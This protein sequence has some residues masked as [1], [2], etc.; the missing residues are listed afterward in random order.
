GIAAKPKKVEFQTMPASPSA[1]ILTAAHPLLGAVQLVLAQTA[2]AALDSSAK[3]SLGTA[4]VSLLLLCWVRYAVHTGLA[5]V[6]ILP[7]R[8]TKVLHST[9]PKYQLLRG[10]FLFLSTFSLF[11][12][13]RYL[14]QA[15]T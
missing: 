8:G 1:R 2:L 9:V 7:M 13:L 6:V 3:W 11:N 10:L 5:L 4:G 12:T 15:E 14:P